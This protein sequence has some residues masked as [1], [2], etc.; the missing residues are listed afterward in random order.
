VTGVGR[1][2]AVQA[3]G[4]SQRGH[5]RPAGQRAGD[6]EER[7]EAQQQRGGEQH[8]PVDEIHRV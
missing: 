6:D 7:E 4:P 8:A 2:L 5:H 1:G 3:G